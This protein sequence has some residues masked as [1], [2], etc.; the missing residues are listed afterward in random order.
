MTKKQAYKIVIKDLRQGKKCKAYAVGCFQCIAWRLSE[1][2][3]DI[4]DLNFNAKW[5]KK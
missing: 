4:F 2:L 3:E 1:D 5:S